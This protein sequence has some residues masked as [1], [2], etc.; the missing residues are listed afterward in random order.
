MHH[1]GSIASSIVSDPGPIII[2]I[3]IVHVFTVFVVLF[4]CTLLMQSMS[5]HRI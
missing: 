2:I 3:C 1:S 5:N 4:H